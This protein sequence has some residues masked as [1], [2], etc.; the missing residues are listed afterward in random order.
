M[1]SLLLLVSQRFA[2]RNVHS[3]SSPSSSCGALTL[4]GSPCFT[5][6]S[7]ATKQMEMP[8]AKS[9]ED[10]EDLLPAL[11]SADLVWP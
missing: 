1:A 7:N 6:K 2:H 4:S 8:P 9:K 5:H 11:I 3:E 10:F